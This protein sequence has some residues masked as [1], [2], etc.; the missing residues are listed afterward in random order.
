[1][2]QQI[3]RG[4]EVTEQIRAEKLRKKK[5]KMKLVEP[6]TIRYGLHYKQSVGDFMKDAYERRKQK[7]HD[8]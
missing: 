6:G 2:Q 5:Q 4:K 1:M 7:R 3:Q 8:K